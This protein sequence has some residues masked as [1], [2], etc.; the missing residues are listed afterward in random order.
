MLTW[1]AKWLFEDKIM[2]ARLKPSEAK[3]Q[4]DE[5]ITKKIWKLLNEADVVIAHN[6]K[7]F[8]IKR[9]NTRFLAHGLGE[10]MPYKVIDTLTHARK[11]FNISSNK[12]DYI[13]T[14]L[15]VGNKVDTGGFELWRRCMQGE[16]AAL[17]EMEVY[18]IQD[19]KLLEDVYLKLRPYI[20]PHPNLGLYIEDNIQSCPSCGSEALKWSGQYATNV[21]LYLAFRCNDC[22]SVGRSRK[23]Y[24]SAKD[25]SNLT[26]SV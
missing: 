7:K 20:S 11:K 2:S 21:N 24:L 26:T 15:G 9:L 8:D 10:P 6:A 16:K 19:V 12:L 23:G 22:Q 1:S 3:E 18:N 4:D 14:F 5:R 25:R 17:K 13:G